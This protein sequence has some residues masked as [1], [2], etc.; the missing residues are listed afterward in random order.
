MTAWGEVFGLHPFFARRRRSSGD[1]VM[2]RDEP[3]GLKQRHGTFKQAAA[4]F[5]AIEATIHPSGDLVQIIPIS[6]AV[7]VAAFPEPARSAHTQ[8]QITPDNIG[9]RHDFRLTPNGTAK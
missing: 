3:L 7:E 9:V 8:V 1:V 2:A 6:G 5:Q 4:I